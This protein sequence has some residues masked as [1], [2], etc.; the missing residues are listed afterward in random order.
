[1]ATP[2]S[3]CPFLMSLCVELC[4]VTIGKQ[5][6]N[7]SRGRVRRGYYED[8]EVAAAVKRWMAGEQGN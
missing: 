7:Y 1:M 8:G 5:S 4:P 2:P 6:D 3:P